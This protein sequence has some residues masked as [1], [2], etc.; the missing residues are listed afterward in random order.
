MIFFRVSERKKTRRDETRK[1]DAPEKLLVKE[2][3]VF[4]THSR[5]GRIL[6]VMT[7]TSGEGDGGGREA[8]LAVGTKH[9]FQLCQQEAAASS[10][11]DKKKRASV[12]VA[13]AAPTATT[14]STKKYS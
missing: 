14:A 8:A 3:P 2:E 5:R 1:Y 13:P 10:L 6:L 4:S 11:P 12:E 9:G 7:L